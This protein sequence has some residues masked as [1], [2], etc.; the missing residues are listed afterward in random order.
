MFIGKIDY[1]VLYLP[2]SD[3]K[4][5]FHWS[6]AGDSA[7]MVISKRVR[8]VYLCGFKPVCGEE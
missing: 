3:G 2:S 5:G 7:G 6:Q 8:I 4:A 1:G